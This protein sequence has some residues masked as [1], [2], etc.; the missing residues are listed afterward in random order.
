MAATSGW[1]IPLIFFFSG[2]SSLLFETSWQRILTLYYGVG[3]IT[4][5]MI[6]SV[7][8]LGL[9]L[10]ALLGGKLA[11]RTTN[12][13]RLYLLIELVLAAYGLFSIPFLAWLG[14]MTAGASHLVAL[15]A[16]TLFLLLPTLAMGMTLPI[17]ITVMKPGNGFF[18]S[19]AFLYTI[20]ALGGAI[21]ALFGTFVVKSF[22]G[23]D[24]AVYLAVA[25]DFALAFA[26]LRL[27]ATTISSQ[28]NKLNGQDSLSMK[29]NLS[30]QENLSVQDNHSKPNSAPL[31]VPL[32][33]VFSGFLAI[34]YEIVLFRFVDILSKA[35]PYIF[36]TN[37]AY[38]L[39][40]I[41]MGSCLTASWIERKQKKR[42]RQD[43]ADTTSLTA[44]FF[45]LQA[46]TGLYIL[47]SFTLYYHALS[48]PTLASVTAQYFTS[49]Y[50]GGA[51]VGGTSAMAHL[52]FILAPCVIMGASF[53]I[54][55]AIAYEQSGKTGS[56]VGRTYFANTIGNVCGGLAVGFLLLP[57]LGTEGTLFALSA[58]GIL[59]IL[60]FAAFSKSDKAAKRLGLCAGAVV[61]V[62]A[63]SFVFPKR[64]QLYV[65]MH[66]SPMSQQWRASVKTFAEEGEDG[67][68][69]LFHNGEHFQ[70]FLNGYSHGTKPDYKYHREFFEA[71]GHMPEAKSVL[72]VGFGSGTITELVLKQP[73]ITDV[74]VVEISGANLRNMRKSP[75]GGCFNDKRLKVVSDDGRRLLQRSAKKYD[76]I[77]L[78]PLRASE[79][80]SNNI[81]SR[82]FFRLA[83][84]RLNND[85]LI[86][87]WLDE[88]HVIPKTVAN[89]FAHVKL[90]N[91]FLL[92]SQNQL[93]LDE[94]EQD[95]LLGL[96]S[97]EERR[98]AFAHDTRLVGDRNFIV[99]KFAAYPINEDLKP[100][101]E[102]F[103]GLHMFEAMQGTKKKQ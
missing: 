91:Y 27:P 14:Q 67:L 38:Y 53:P 31:P 55:S 45:A 72:I 73:Q 63:F 11:D 71:I 87:L 9:G 93:D 56:A 103:I 49:G 29:D 42:Q 30:V 21:G 25:I 16:M 43:G 66:V 52:I 28:A 2:F 88:H 74:T 77:L 26:L 15:G 68:A 59:S 78:D 57:L 62:I 85:G 92:A 95:R 10:G 80:Y 23:L 98:R 3:S 44:V 6:V 96:Y 89:V 5:T 17:V 101:C 35:S 46:L 32:L 97:E 8:M 82:E 39:C 41:A 64:T 54:L 60:V 34:A 40:G 1:F 76:L 84:S 90:F 20:N 86:M 22:F 13:G 37:L 81:Y 99:S 4:A 33:A 50:V 69:L 18:N 51:M 48:I 12:P 58:A 94:K 102:Y 19:L 83:S 79:A 47:A 36:A 24:T 7:F 65:A 75:L 100:A 61:A 70:N